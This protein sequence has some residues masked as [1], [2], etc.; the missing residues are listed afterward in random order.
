MQ[1]LLG[2][3]DRKRT[4]LALDRKLS[5]L[6]AL[7]VVRPEAVGSDPDGTQREAKILGAIGAHD[8]IVSLFDMDL[9]GA[10]H[11]L[12]FEYLAG[13]T[14]QEHLEEVSREGGQIAAQ[15]LLR[16]GRQL[17]RGLSHIHH[18]GVVHRDLSP[19]N[20]W[21]DERHVA[22]LGDF[23]S[24]IFLTDDSAFRPL[25]TN[26]YAS[27]E[28]RGGGHLD[29]RSDLFSLGAVLAVVASGTNEVNIDAPIDRG[30]SDLPSG[31][32]SLLDTLV[33]TSPVDRPRSAEEVLALL[34]A[35]RCDTGIESL[36]AQGEGERVEFKATLLTPT[37][38]VR[39]TAAD[40]KE[41]L[42]AA[43]R[44]MQQ[45][46]AHEVTRTVAAFLN[47]GGGD[48]LIGVEDSGRVTGIERDLDRVPGKRQD[49]DPYDA[50]LLHLKNLIGGAL[51]DDVWAAVDL[52]LAPA[53]GSTVAKVSCQPRSVETWLTKDQNEEFYVRASNSTQHLRPSSAATYI[54]EHWPR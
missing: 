26:T 5:R 14:L 9:E 32:R 8:N 31:F 35:M 50:W 33:A 28:E 24:A 42:G 2:E 1:R 49:Q 47:S 44:R 3:G 30:R 38:P 23:D 13:G 40:S 41:S 53:A 52:R 16:L 48:L 25:T 22:H 12:A 39:Q 18:K 19:G 37:K 43:H 20:V 27:P 21:F 54:R 15:D 46:L 10:V 6:V 51:G 11:Y 45:T 34:D 4:Y 7:A 36:V 17:C 29:Q